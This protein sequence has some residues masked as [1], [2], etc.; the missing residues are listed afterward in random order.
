V[1]TPLDD[2]SV[3]ERLDA[4]EPPSSPEEAQARAPYEALL[5]RIEAMEDVAP[6]AGWEDRAVTRWSVGRRRRRIAVALA[7]SATIGLLGVLLLQPCAMPSAQPLEVAVLTAPGS[8][9]RGDAAV[10]DT[11]R[12][13][14]R[15]DRPHVELRI[16]TGTNLIA[17]CPD[18]ERCR[19]DASIVELEWKLVESGAYQ[20]VALSSASEI[21]APTDGGADRDLLEAGKTAHVE[22]RHLV[23][24][25]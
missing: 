11:L 2:D 13:R 9:R 23:V 10:G 6:P 15:V 5:G 24:S 4:G 20:I 18:S 22:I 17:R 7:A 12:V 19:R 21:S 8:T 1:T 14:A 25:P 3:I 16:Y